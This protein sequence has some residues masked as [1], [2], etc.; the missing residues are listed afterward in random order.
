MTSA[1]R[2]KRRVGI[3][4]AR[5]AQNGSTGWDSWVRLCVLLDTFVASLPADVVVVSGGAAGIDSRAAKKARDRLIEVVE[6]RPD[7]ATH[8]SRAPLERN[9]LIAKDCDE[10]HA[11]P[12]VWS[13]GT[14]DTVRKAR[15][16]GIPVTIH[17]DA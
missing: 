5:P 6:Y 9:T 11:F 4:G 14:W 17:G 2:K 8:G 1:L 12:A 16:R 15:L 3:V 13:R 10:L 7:Y